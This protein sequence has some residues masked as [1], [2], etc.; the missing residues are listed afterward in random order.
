MPSQPCRDRDVDATCAAECAAVRQL[1]VSEMVI[2]GRGANGLGVEAG[3]GSSDFPFFYFPAPVKHPGC[4]PKNHLIRRTGPGPNAKRECLFVRT[5]VCCCL[6]SRPLRDTI[7]TV[8]TRRRR[9]YRDTGNG[10]SRYYGTVRSVENG[11][12]WAGMNS[13]ISK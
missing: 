5:A 12:S 8:D 3:A 4:D 6:L 1:S 2:T 9:R 11:V 10:V 13:S 7:H